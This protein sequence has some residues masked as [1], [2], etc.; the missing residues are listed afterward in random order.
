MSAMSEA[1]KHGQLAVSFDEQA[2]D[3]IF[4]ELDQCHLPGVA[5]GVA[6]H[7]TPVYRKGFGLAS[8]ELPIVLS[9][10][11]RMRIGSVTKQFTAFAYLLLCE[12]GHA[13]IDDPVK[14]FLP[15]FHPVTH[16]VTMRQL[17]AHTSG[18]RDATDIKFRFGGFEGQPV[19]CD[20]ILSLYR[21]LNDADC[22]PGTSW[23]YNNGCYMILSAV[24]EGIA[25]QPLEQV[26]KQLIFA[27]IGMHDTLLRRWDTDFVPNSATPH[28][29]TPAGR[30][31][32][33]YWGL[34]FAGAGGMVST[35][36]D[37]LRWLA[38]MDT[39]SVGSAGTW[40]AM[41]M[42]HT[43]S[44]GSSTGYGFGLI[45]GQY[46]G[47]EVI[48]HGGGWIGGNAQVMKVPAAGLDI[49][50]IANR[51]DAF[52]PVLAN[53][54]VDVCLAGLDPAGKVPDSPANTQAFAVFN[55]KRKSD[56][57]DAGPDVAVSNDTFSRG[58]FRSSTTGR[59]VQ[60]FANDGCQIVSIDGHDLPYVRGE[61]GILRPIP[62]WSFIKR[63]VTLR[64]DPANPSSVT[65][66][67]FGNR[68]ELT[69]VN[70]P[71]QVNIEAI[72]GR[73]WSDTTGTG[74]LIDRKEDE[75]RMHA[76]GRFGSM[77]YEL[78]CLEEGVWRVNSAISIFLDSIITFDHDASALY[79]S[80]YNTR[81]LPFRRVT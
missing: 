73:Y 12:A 60:L 46:R 16:E 51:T 19:T 70:T 74:I 3:T 76:R 79:L 78:S 20:E 9:P 15:Q 18:L 59:V 10:G 6:L 17:M 49:V 69:R 40:A 29:L 54:I 11:I 28:A 34:D 39:P 7:G 53:Q 48:H 61:E 36:D 35:I 71:R 26:L 2:L 21:D 13:A 8:L 24:I 22:P 23:M 43:L 58:V 30:Y 66:S 44:N 41:K 31:E 77:D 80:S 47:V 62:I 33:R 64:G 4:R 67:D 55:V 50:V 5:V 42:P 65:L 75:V 14:K 63:I 56:R 38:H 27:P 1:V 45:R 68:D 37:L 81:S 25:G 57:P 52:A 32:K 72:I